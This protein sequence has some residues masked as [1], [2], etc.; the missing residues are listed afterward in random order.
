MKTTPDEKQKKLSKHPGGRPSVL[1]EEVIKKLEQVFSLG[2]TDLEACFYADISHQTLYNYQNAHPEF[3]ER[4][5]AL[6]EQPILKARQ[7]VVK[8]LDDVQNAQWYLERKAKKEFAQ[9]TENQVDVVGTT[10]N[11]IVFGDS[12]KLTKKA[13][14]IHVPPQL[15]TGATSTADSPTSGQV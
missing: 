5:N 6:K 8:S 9:R 11:I 14:A 4:K 12:D 1:T 2:G 7:T 3:V 10:L 15:D 13:S